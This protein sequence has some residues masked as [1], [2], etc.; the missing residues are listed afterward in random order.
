MEKI[1]GQQ[2]PVTLFKKIENVAFKDIIKAVRN[3]R[4]KRKT[5]VSKGLMRHCHSGLGHYFVV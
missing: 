1:N 3:Q 2:A 5:K 4:S